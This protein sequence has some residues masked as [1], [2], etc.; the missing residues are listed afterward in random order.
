MNGS[1]IVVRPCEDP[2]ERI[3]WDGTAYS[4]AADSIVFSKI[5]TGEFSEPPRPLNMACGKYDH[6]MFHGEQWAR[7]NELAWRM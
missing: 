4:E 7:I 5:S 2:S 1:Q 3:I 6:S